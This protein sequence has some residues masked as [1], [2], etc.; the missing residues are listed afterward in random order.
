MADPEV[1]GFEHMG[2]DPRLLQ[3]PGGLRSRPAWRGRQVPGGLR[4]R[5]VW[6]GRR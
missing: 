2:L 5:P 6:R 3:V 4:N 1:L